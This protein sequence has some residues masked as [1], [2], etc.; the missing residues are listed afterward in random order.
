[1]SRL[2]DP[3][4]V[5]Q[6]AL[7]RFDL[8]VSPLRTLSLDALEGAQALAFVGLLPTRFGLDSDQRWIKARSTP[9]QRRTA[10][11]LAPALHR[12][13]TGL[14][15]NQLRT[16]PEPRPKLK[17]QNEPEGS[18]NP[19]HPAQ[20]DGATFQS[21]GRGIRSSRGLRTPCTPCCRTWV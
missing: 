8:D 3:S 12:P 19:M 13:C 6:A 2:D 5:N 7:G 15:S 21:A 17:E 16:T 10:T 20:I 11:G 14:A 1:M 18:V 9:V 4:D